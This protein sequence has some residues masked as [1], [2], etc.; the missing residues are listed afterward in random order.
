MNFKSISFKLQLFNICLL[1]IVL[2]V[3]IFIIYSIVSHILTSSVDDRLVENAFEAQARYEGF[4]LKFRTAERGNNGRTVELSPLPRKSAPPPD[5]NRFNTI[6]DEEGNAVYHLGRSLD[7]LSSAVPVFDE[8]AFKKTL[9]TGE[10]KFSTIKHEDNYGQIIITRVYYMRFL[11]D[12]KM[13]IVQSAAP[14]DE[15]AIAAHS[16]FIMMIILLPFGLIIAYVAGSIFTH[17]TLGPINDICREAKNLNPNDLSL[18]LPISGNDEF[19]ELSTTVNDMLAKVEES[20]NKLEKSY[21]REKRFTSDVSHEL[22]TPL[23]A[24]K[25]QSSLAREVSLTEEEYKEAIEVIDNSVN[26]T[27]NIINDLLLL[28]RSDS[29][30]MVLKFND[31]NIAELL[32]DVISTLPPIKEE[33]KINVDIA[34]DVLDITADYTALYRLFTNIMTNSIKYTDSGGTINIEVKPADDNDNMVFIFADNGIGISEH[35]LEHI[36][37]RFYRVD[38]ARTNVDISGTGLGLAISKSIVGAHKGKLEFSS[39]LGYGTT[40]NIILPINNKG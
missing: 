22:R 13:M 31:I 20:Y 32:D 7:V 34:E 2:S 16:M 14:Y 11:K 35:D 33:Y 1:G 12:Q 28:A 39:E 17:R 18:R 5:F 25:A 30:Q 29:G 23:T 19:T 9:E 6:F 37:E 10:P 21:N 24:L 4:N 3:F 36:T 8:T 27:I 26:K 40:V 15:V 38:K